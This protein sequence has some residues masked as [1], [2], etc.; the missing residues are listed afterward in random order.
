MIDQHPFDLLAGYALGSLDE[1]DLLIVAR[2]LPGCAVCR[3]EVNAYFEVADQLALSA[4]PHTPPPGLRDRILQRVAEAPVME[5]APV[6]EAPV[7]AHPLPQKALERKQERP[8]ERE[9]FFR[10]LFSAR[11]LALAVAVMAILLVALAGLLWQQMSPSAGDNMRIV[12]LQ[13]T[14]DAPSVQG[15]L[16]VFENE[17]YG[18]LVVEHAPPLDY[19]HQYQLWLIKDGKRTSG[20]VF[21]VYDD[22]YGVLQ[23]EADY[24]LN[25][26]QSFGVTVEPEGGSYAPTGKRVLAGENK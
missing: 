24:P 5:A 20:G 7:P 11:P 12:R 23:V 25:E 4:T 18:T 8:P 1:E 10:R 2:H 22:G 26:Y 6:Y 17:P 15:Y 3:A 16:M 21:S 9:G 13:G 19:E 14:E